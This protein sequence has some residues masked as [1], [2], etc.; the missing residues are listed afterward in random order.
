MTSTFEF[1][2]RTCCG[3]G[4]SRRWIGTTRLFS[5]LNVRRHAS[6]RRRGDKLY[7]RLYVTRTTASDPFPLHFGE[8]ETPISALFPLFV[9]FLYPLGLN[10][11]DP[12]QQTAPPEKPRE[13]ARGSTVPYVVTATHGS[14]TDLGS[15]RPSVQG[16][17]QGSRSRSAP[18]LAISDHPR[19]G[20]QSVGRSVGRRS[21]SGKP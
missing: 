12:S 8:L 7:H 17:G 20:P 9:A 14:R 18:A 6:Y 21:Q 16:S 15:I 1:I 11:P 2:L 3:L 4:A 19:T 10:Q 5:R 13:C